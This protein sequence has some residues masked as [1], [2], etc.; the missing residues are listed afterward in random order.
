MAER[1]V[2]AVK[3]GGDGAVCVFDGIVR[4]NT[5]GRATLHLD[6]EAYEEMALK[7]MRALRDEAKAQLRC[8]RDRNRAS[9]RTARSW[10]KPAC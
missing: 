7:Q 8:A 10:A 1:I 6:Y 3:S 4:D 2:S 5:R 9:D